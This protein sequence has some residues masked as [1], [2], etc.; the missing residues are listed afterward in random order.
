MSHMEWFRRP[1]GSVAISEVGARPP[2][3]RFVN[4]ISWAHDFDLFRSWA[5]VVVNGR[6]EP[7]ARPFAA[8]AAYLRAQGRGRVRRVT[9]LDPI[10]RELGRWVVE[11]RIPSPGQPTSGTYEGEGF[12]MLR[13]PDTDFVREALRRIVSSVRVE[14]EAT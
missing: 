12:V 14:V 2:G 6:F 4:L 11:K 8:G 10:L 9:G 3:A 1:D 5:D 13:H 7:R